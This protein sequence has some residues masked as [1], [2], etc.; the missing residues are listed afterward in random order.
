MRRDVTTADAVLAAAAVAS[1]PPALRER[2]MRNH[3]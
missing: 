3:Q 1:T 2:E